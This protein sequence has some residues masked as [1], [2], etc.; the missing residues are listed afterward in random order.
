MANIHTT[1]AVLLRVFREGVQE[2]PS[3][4]LLE[5]LVAGVLE[6]AEDRHDVAAVERVDLGGP[7][8]WQEM[9]TILS[10]AAG[11]VVSVGVS[12]GLQKT[13]F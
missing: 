6:L 13:H 5:L 11:A 2:T 12:L 9:D 7:E 10:Y 1:G 3:G 8:L 4:R